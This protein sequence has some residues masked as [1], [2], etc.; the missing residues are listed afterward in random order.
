M[1]LILKFLKFE[2]IHSCL[3]F[4]ELLQYAKWYNVLTL[5][6]SYMLGRKIGCDKSCKENE[7]RDR[8]EES[9][10]GWWHG[11]QKRLH[12]QRDLNGTR[13]QVR[14]SPEREQPGHGV[15]MTTAWSRLVLFERSDQWGWCQ[16]FWELLIFIYLL[17]TWFV[18]FVRMQ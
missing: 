4:P 10:L 16:D 5:L 9:N 12:F 6:D 15:G 8:M 14:Q 7:S 13:E 17:V 18:Q 2:F 1:V 11:S 3:Q